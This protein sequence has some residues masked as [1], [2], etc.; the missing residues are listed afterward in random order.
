MRKKR[1]W[2]MV[3]ALAVTSFVTLS[4]VAAAA[5]YPGGG[6]WTYGDSNGGDFPNYYHFRNIIV[7]L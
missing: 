6:I 1:K 2:L 5:Q 7:Q 3:L 4:G